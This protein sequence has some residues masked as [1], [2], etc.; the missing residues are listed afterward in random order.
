MRT[1][2]QIYGEINE[3]QRNE[4]ALVDLN[5]TSQTSIW[6][7]I[8]RQFSLLIRLFEVR[9][10]TYKADILKQIDEQEKGDLYYYVQ[11]CKAF[12]FG[13]LLKV[14]RF[15]VYY[16]VIDYT[17]QIIAQCSANE[18]F[19]NNGLKILIKSA[20]R[21]TTGLLT[22]LSTIEVFSLLNY[23]DNIKYAGIRVEVRSVV[24]DVMKLKI[25]AK[26]NRS[27][28]NANGT[29][30]LNTSYKPVESG[31]LSFIQNLP[32]DSVFRWRELEAFIMKL[33]AVEDVS[34]TA[35][36]IMRPAVVGVVQAP[37]S[38]TQA[39]PDAKGSGNIY[40]Y[41][42]YA[43]T[44][45]TGGNYNVKISYS[46]YETATASIII[47][48]VARTLYL[49]TTGSWYI[50]QDS[51]EL[52][53]IPLVSGA[54]VI[55]VGFSSGDFYHKSVTVRASANSVVSAAETAFVMST[56]SE[57]GYFTLDPTSEFT[58]V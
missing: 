34:I 37:I 12:Q 10:E 50:Y 42:D 8:K 17:K 6:G 51:N 47:A 5:S 9:I 33:D 53:D 7:L 26:M 1:F 39:F 48:G 44:V 52:T 40:E 38:Y 24:G 43:V 54:N 36:S 4:P 23:I 20:K 46:T 15:G 58:Y 11:K 56:I 28:C 21:D 2:E 18:V 22:P 55:R 14:N 57:A 41:R 32:F 31:V 13:D 25:M 16:D 30:I 27:L 3:A 49:G 35:S 19:D 29:L 45:P